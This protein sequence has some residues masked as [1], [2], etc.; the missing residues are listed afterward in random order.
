MNTITMR[1]ALTN[2]STTQTSPLKKWRIFITDWVVQA[3]V[4]IWPH[5]Q[6]QPQDIRINITCDV[7]ASM[8]QDQ[9]S[10]EEIVCYDQLL[11]S[12]QALVEGQHFY[13]IETLAEA[14]ANQCLKDS[15][16][17]EV[18]VRVEKLAFL[19]RGGGLGIEI[20]RHQSK[21]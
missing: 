10:T 2:L 9:A 19:P 15:R 20:T 12:I 5:E 18:L 1:N 3:S 8:P 21:L 11:Q 14:I 17:Q 16:I 7:E 4:G 13:L 6:Q